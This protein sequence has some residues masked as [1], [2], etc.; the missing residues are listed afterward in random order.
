MTERVRV[1]L[2][3]LGREGQREGGRDRGRGGGRRQR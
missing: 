1:I 3:N 2:C